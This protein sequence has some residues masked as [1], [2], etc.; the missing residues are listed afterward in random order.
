MK[1]EKEHMKIVIVGHVDHGKSTL[2][3][4]LF[5][6]TDS[7]PRE[8][9]EEVKKA[10]KD[11]GKE[12]EFAYLMDHL[13]EER[14][15]GITIDTAQTFFK[16]AKRNYVIID[17]PGHK[18]FIKNM[19]TGASQADTAILIVDAKEGVQEQTKRHAFILGLLGLKQVIVVLNK[20]D[21]VEF[22]EERFNEVKKEIIEF[23][24]TLSIKPVHIVP[25]SARLGDNI[26]FKSTKMKWYSGL[27]VL[28]AL[29]SLKLETQS[30]KPL[31][32]PVQG[33]LKVGDKRILMG[34]VESGSI[35]EGQEI[36]FLPS[37]KK[38]KV[39]SIE[40][41]L[42]EKHSAIAGE[43]TGITIDQPLFIERGEVAFAGR[44]P[45]VK[46]EFN[47]SI[48]WMAKQPFKLGEKLV[49]RC[50]TQE[51]ECEIKAI[52]SRIDSS[53]LKTIEENST[54]L[55]ENEVGKVIIKTK[56]PVVLENFNEIEELGRFVLVR[57]ENV[58]A[59]G[60]ISWL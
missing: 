57:G 33:V 13:Q 1:K 58:S 39:K 49:F 47:A 22:K 20:M 9:I 42:K 12:M 2:I 53:T 29:D 60:T 24:S 6:D 11:L 46:N 10:C 34:R 50:A 21:L 37:G 26:A 5:Y 19:I 52:K 41:F 7:I 31:R 3:G 8:K 32:F 44:K 40:E 17:A 16:T 48:F 38:A 59:G 14:E 35:S 56:K 30:I 27:T 55:N 4:R 18:E 43:S 45:F 25:V 28:K 36:E 15:Q 54:E 51:T 23:L